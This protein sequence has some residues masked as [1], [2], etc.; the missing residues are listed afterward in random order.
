MATQFKVTFR[1]TGQLNGPVPI[2][3]TVE[4]DEVVARSFSG[5]KKDEVILS[6]L[7][8]FYPGVEINPRQIG[9]QI[10]EVI[11]PKKEKKSKKN[12]ISKKPTP[13]FAHPWWLFPFRIIWR[14]LRW[15]FITIFIEKQ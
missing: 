2:N 5:S 11:S 14:I 15:F 6:A 12:K 9:I 1:G 13:I 10:Q 4:Y 8:G 7:A 3:K